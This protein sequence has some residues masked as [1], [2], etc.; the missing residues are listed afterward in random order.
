[1]IKCSE[2]W[3]K[4]H[5]IPKTPKL[6]QISTCTDPAQELAIMNTLRSLLLAGT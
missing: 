4:S 5:K 2:S 3:H 6:P 1:M